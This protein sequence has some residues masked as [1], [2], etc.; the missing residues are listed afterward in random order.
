[1]ENLVTSLREMIEN[2]NLIMGVLSKKRD[3][4]HP[5][6]KVKIQ[7]VLIKDQIVYQFELFDG[8]QV[9]HLNLD[10]VETLEKVYELL[11]EAFLQGMFF[12]GRGD[13]QVLISKKNKVKVLKKKATRELQVVTAHNRKKNYII[14]DGEPCDFLQA[15]GV[16]DEDGRVKKSRYDKFRQLNRYL[17]IIQSSIKVL[18]K[19]E[20]IRI[21]DFGCGKAYLT[22]ALYYYLVK[23]LHL[24]VEIIGLD[25]KEDVIHFCNQLR[26]D[27]AYEGLRFEIG[28]IEHYTSSRPVHMVISLHACDTATDA[29]LAKAVGWG[30][31][32]I[33]A[34]P[35]CQ[36]ELLPQLKTQHLDV[37]ERHGILKERLAAL[38][39]DAIRA[40]AMEIMGYET[41]I[42]EFIDM[43]HT[44]KNLMI[45]SVKR[46]HYS[47]EEVVRYKDTLKFFNVKPSIEV[48]LGA[49]FMER[50][51]G[52]S[53]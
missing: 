40:S 30:S 46:G 14:D 4:S 41:D 11:Q 31:E 33:L 3:K 10:E 13:Y 29:A 36:H 34:V 50:V 5:V 38:T 16:M 39:T 45:R 15:L 28:N 6:E 37:M 35:C 1:M 52:A 9:Q 26:D 48:F 53:E 7:P 27:L 20:T 12:C 25:L 19:E 23:I 49:P 42:F 21:I 18:N 17:E 44:P 51:Y 22:F 8:K 47:K 24:N 2:Q 32:V 43:A